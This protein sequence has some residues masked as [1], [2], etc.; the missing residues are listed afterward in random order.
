MPLK[1]K[2]D[3]STGHLVYFEDKPPS[4][5]THPIVTAMLIGLAAS[6][7]GIS[8]GVLIFIAPMLR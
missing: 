4:I 5:Y 3:Y 7:I 1:V 8:L 2:Y 6:V